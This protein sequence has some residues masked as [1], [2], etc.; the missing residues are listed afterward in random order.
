MMMHC[1]VSVQLVYN[2]LWWHSSQV[3]LVVYLVC[4]TVMTS[5]HID[6]NFHDNNRF[7]LRQSL[8]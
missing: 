3:I 1:C 5:E 6:L 2:E 7:P 4:I 8:T